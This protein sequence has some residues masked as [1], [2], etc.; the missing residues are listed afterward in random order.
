MTRLLERSVCERRAP[1]TAKEGARRAGPAHTRL[2]GVWERPAAMA[3]GWTEVVNRP[4]G[5]RRSGPEAGH[6]RDAGHGHAADHGHPIHL[7]LA[8]RQRVYGLPSQE[9]RSKTIDIV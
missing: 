2:E 3:G 4:I 8:G 9:H 5:R 1:G 7:P 6:P